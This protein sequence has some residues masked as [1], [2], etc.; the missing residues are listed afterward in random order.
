M[1]FTRRLACG[2]S[3]GLLLVGGAALAQEHGSKDEA[4][5]LADSAW[6]HVKKVGKD[7]AFKDFSTDKANWTRKDLYVL[8][9]DFNGVTLAHGGNA[10]LVGK[11]MLGVKDANGEAFVTKMIAAAQSPAGSGW[12]DYDW[13]HP[14]TK[15]IEGKSTYVRKLPGGDGFVGV[16]IYR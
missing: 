6:E 4:K 11:G 14:Q 7:Q 13:P 15:K 2:L 12:V 1:N 5:A 10:R 3:L 9:T 16:G 8:A